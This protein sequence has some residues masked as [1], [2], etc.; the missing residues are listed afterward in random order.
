MA[1]RFQTFG[2]AS[3]AESHSPVASFGATISHFPSLSTFCSL[4]SFGFNTCCRF[5][6]CGTHWDP[7]V[8]RLARNFSVAIPTSLLLVP[9]TLA[10]FRFPYPLLPSFRCDTRLRFFFRPLS[11]FHPTFR[12]RLARDFTVAIPLAIFGFQSRFAILGFDIRSRFFGLDSR[13]PFPS[14]LAVFGPCRLVENAHGFRSHTFD[15]FRGTRELS[16]LVS[17]HMLA[18]RMSIHISLHV[19]IVMSIH[20][21]ELSLL[22][23]MHMSIHMSSHMPIS[24]R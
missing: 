21:P 10:I 17:M 16:L 4:T 20:A 19:S 13:L 15:P 14:M 24:S 23:S 6:F 5:F 12:V 2:L 8:E 18:K 3:N 11:S 9:I 22:M 7:S 1:G